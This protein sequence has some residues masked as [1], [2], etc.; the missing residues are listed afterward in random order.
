MFDLFRSRDKAVRYMLAGLLFVVAASMVITLIPGFGSSS[1]ARSDDTTI[2]EV[3]GTKITTKD[4][5]EMI[6]RMVRS[7]QIPPDMLEVYL[8]QFIEANIQTH[9]AVYEAERMGLRVSDDEVLAG[10]ISN[11]P[12][13]F[14]N[15][16]LASKEQFENAVRQNG[17][18]MEE[19]V[20]AMRNQLLMTKP[21]HMTLVGIIVTPHA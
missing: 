9:A 14:P 16:V 2:A 21:H 18:T 13:F 3:A 10:M 15:G 17:H 8:P 6:Q 5:Q 12:S 1:S 4:I 7:N 19:E 20:E 11:Y